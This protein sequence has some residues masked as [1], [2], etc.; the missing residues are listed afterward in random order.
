MSRKTNIINHFIDIT[1]LT[2]VFF[3]VFNVFVGLV[4]M[5]GLSNDSMEI[6]KNTERFLF[7]I[8]L[9]GG[10]VMLL[11]DYMEYRN[12]PKKTIYDSDVES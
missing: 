6:W 5:F 1:V 12:L 4:V 3:A 7:I 11:A 10:A 8:S 9:L 2:F